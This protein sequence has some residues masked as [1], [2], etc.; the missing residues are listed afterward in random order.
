MIKFYDA[1]LEHLSMLT[2][3]NEVF[4][5]FPSLAEL[6]IVTDFRGNIEYLLEKNPL[7]F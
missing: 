6:W 4:S 5:F 3:V 1:I 7:K 2:L